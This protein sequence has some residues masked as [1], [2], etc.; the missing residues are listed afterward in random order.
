MDRCG[1]SHFPP[2]GQSLASGGR[3]RVVRLQ[4]FRPSMRIV[5]R[6]TPQTQSKI[7]TRDNEVGPPPFPPP[8]PQAE[9]VIRPHEAKPGQPVELHVTIKNAGKGPVYRM[10]GTTQ[11]EN[12]LFDGQVFYF[13]K[14]KAGQQQSDTVRVQVPT[15]HDQDTASMRIVFEEYNGFTPSPLEA[16][17]HLTGATKPR[18]AYNYQIL[19]DGSGQ[20]VGNGDGRIQKGEAVDLLLTLRNVSTV[21]A[22]NT[23]VEINNAADQHL[24][25][26]PRVI[27]FGPLEGETSKQAKVSF[28]VWPDFPGSELQFKLFIQEKNRTSLSE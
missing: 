14:I 15:D 26:R 16:V 5:Q 11:S 19:D 12:L 24:N 7:E 6:G 21:P 22:K 18:L 13:G 4:P 3:D 28:T 9:L 23:W 20:S 17:I 10:K 25:I 27:R 8:R 2:D 1:L